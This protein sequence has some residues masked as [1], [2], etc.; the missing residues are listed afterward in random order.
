MRRNGFSSRWYTFSGRCPRLLKTIVTVA[1]WLIA[2]ATLAA[3]G[4]EVPR[5][6]TEPR[7]IRNPNPR[8][9]LVA[10]LRFTA[11][12]RV[13]TSIVLSDGERDWTVNF[14]ASHDPIEGLAILGMR[15]GRR[16]ELTVS[17]KDDAG[18]VA[19]APRPLTY[20]TPPLPGDLR[21]FPPISVKRSEPARMEPGFTLLSVRRANQS[22]PLKRTPKQWPFTVDWGMI[23]AIDAAGEVVWYYQSDKRIA[24]IDR[25]RNGHLFFHLTDSR[26]VELDMLGNE[27]NVW[28]AGKRPHGP[29][30]G[31]IP[32]AVQSL[33]HQPH[34]MPSGNFLAMSANARKLP[35]YYTSEID[36]NAPRAEQMVM[37]DTIVEFERSGKIVWSW[38]SFDHL[39]PYRIGYNTFDSYWPTR[40]FPNHLDWTHGNGVAYDPRDDSVIMS[41][42]LQDAVLKADRESGEIKW[43][44]GVDDG[45]NEAL[46]KKV[47]K[48]VGTVRWPYHGHNP[49]IT[50]AGTIVM[51]DNGILGARPFEPWLPPHK[52]F[53]R[54]VEFEI[55]EDNMTVRQLWASHHAL[56]D[57][58]T[59]NSWAMGD[60]H[61]LPKTDNMLVI[62]SMCMTKRDDYTW[63]EYGNEPY[64][65]DYPFTP[66]IREYTHTQ[67][68]EIVFDIEI[69]D[70]HDL[71]SWNVYGGMRVPSLYPAR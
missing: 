12:E 23:V 21:D 28:F 66:R 56:D 9:P 64:P 47:L 43:I 41:L 58:D 7:I 5:F 38:N 6:T 45:W 1:A 50:H 35:N 32:V 71:F 31:G 60:A 51:Y 37:G 10:L 68:A 18:N 49:R 11:S 4:L 16:H 27:V 26:S 69:S 61:R 8:V 14:D 17:I 36:P 29:F 57:K 54:A 65:D 30:A 22:R 52:T 62:D 67:P 55:D 48:P 15:P 24:G 40:G 70:P 42:R 25:L 34:E 59:C 63:D 44:L 33:H 13:S 53:S 19:D 46:S 39:D 20:T 3:A 2:C